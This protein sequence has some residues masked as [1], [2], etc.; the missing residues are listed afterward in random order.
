MRYLQLDE[1]TKFPESGFSDPLKAIVIT[2]AELSLA[3]RAALGQWL[4]KSGCLYMMAWGEGSQAI[5]DAVNLANLQA[6]EFGKIPD[7]HLVITTSH[8]HES[9]RDVFWYCK[10][11]AMHPCLLLE[12]ILLLHLADNNRENNLTRQYLDA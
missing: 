12:N 10:H 3:Q 5:Q 9:L 6:H 2:E 1:V 11:T 7:E 8:E 4:V